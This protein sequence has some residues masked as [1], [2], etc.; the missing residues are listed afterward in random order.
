MRKSKCRCCGKYSVTKEQLSRINSLEGEGYQYNKKLVS[1]NG[2]DATTP[3]AYSDLAYICNFANVNN[4]DRVYYLYAS[5][6][7]EISRILDYKSDIKY[8]SVAEDGNTFVYDYYLDED[9]I[10]ADFTNSLLVISGI[11]DQS[12]MKF[13]KVSRSATIYQR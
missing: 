9:L 3:E 7:A 11:D 4:V 6:P 5:E 10:P 12:E 8:L 1:V 2:Y 13:S